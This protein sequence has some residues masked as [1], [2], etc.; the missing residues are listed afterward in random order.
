MAHQEQVDFCLSVK[1]RFPELFKNATVVDIG[2]LDINGNNR[3]LFDNCNYVGIDIGEGKNVDIVSKGH[4]FTVTSKVDIVIS[5]ECFEHDQYWDKTIKNIVENLLKKGGMFLFTCA[6][7]GRAEHGTRKAN[8][9]CSPL[10]A[11]TNGWEDYYLNLTEEDIRTAIDIDAY[12]AEYE[13]FVNTISCDL[14][15]WGLRR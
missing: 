9:G 4:E 6:T 15:F 8:A 2:S 12:F 5:S 14:Y 13:F 7:T 11:I 10:T 3:Y 1:D